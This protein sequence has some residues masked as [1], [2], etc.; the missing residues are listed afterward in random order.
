LSERS[1]DESVLRDWLSVLSRQRWIVLVA[2]TVVPVLAFAASQSQQRLYEA[3]ATVLLNEQNP[4][5]AEALNLTSAPP[6]TPDRF[7]A[8]QAKLARMGEVAQSAVQASRLPDR[9]AAALLANSSVSADL[10]DDL[11]TFSVADPVP[12]VAKR[13]ANEYARAFTRY[14]HRLDNAALSAALRGT[15]RKLDGI[16]ASGGGDSALFRRLEATQRDLED[17]QTLQAAASSAKVVGRAGSPVLVQPRTKRNVI[18]AVI[19]GLAFGVAMAFFRETLDTR[20][21]SA[22]ELRELLGVPLL[23]QVPKP[24][25]PLT[26]SKRLA[27]LADPTGAS[28]EAFGILKANLEISQLEHHAD[29]IA[30]TTPVED[31][32]GS[33]IAANLAVILARSGRRVILADLNL[34][35]PTVAALLGVSERPGLTDV[36]TGAPL[37]D[38]LRSIDVHPDRPSS[39]AGT[40]DVLTVGHPPPDPGD[41]LLSSAVADA[42]ELMEARCDVLLLATPSLLAA[43]EAMTIASHADALILVAGIDRVPR[44]AL[45]ET[46]RVLERCPTFTLGV[47]ATGC[48]AAG[49]GDHGGGSRAATTRARTARV[50][51]AS[52]KLVAQISASVR[53]LASAPA[54][55]PPKSRQARRAGGRG[56]SAGSPDRGE[57]PPQVRDA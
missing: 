13:L 34:R 39:A 31:E 38:A 25:R 49:R 43:G 47:I 33:A 19:A 23:G 46:R 42:L 15:R 1:G 14:R 22:D 29:S 55:R 26:P 44:E 12:I 35:R 6:S 18:L 2:V 17:L 11:L 56:L 52:E 50:A 7:V 28:T 51:G 3:S 30:I 40:L 16:V 45:V 48:K 24:A 32:G 57:R 36:A 20:V 54:R 53:S 9:A 21:R 41:F 10:T 27:T 4:S 8:T 37:G 5:A